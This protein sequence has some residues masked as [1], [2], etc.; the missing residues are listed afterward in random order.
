M[1]TRKPKTVRER[2]TNPHSSERNADIS[3]RLLGVLGTHVLHLKITLG[4]LNIP[5][6]VF[7]LCMFINLWDMPVKGLTNARDVKTGS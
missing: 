2:I 6:R 1:K 7:K 4:V 3:G 5:S